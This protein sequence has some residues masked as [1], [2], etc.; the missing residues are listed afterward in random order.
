MTI[1]SILTRHFK[2]Y[3]SDTWI[4]ENKAESIHQVACQV[5]HRII[6]EKMKQ[7]VLWYM[8]NNIL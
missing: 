2:S 6:Q 3:Y 5:Y 7:L 1:I 4:Y 8:L